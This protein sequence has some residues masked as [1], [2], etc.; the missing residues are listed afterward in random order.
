MEDKKYPIELEVISPLAVGNGNDKEWIK[1]LDFVQKDDKVY[2]LD[3]HKAVEQGVDVGRLTN[4]FLKYD[5]KGILQL[6]G[7]NVD[8][9]AK[10]VFVSPM[11]TE[12]KIKAFIRTQLFDKPIVAG[13]S[14]KG[15]IRSALF[16][17]LRTT[18]KSNEEVFG[19]MNEGTDFMRFI[20][21]GDVEM[22]STILVNSKIYN[23][24]G[25][26][27]QWQG[28]WKHAR[29]NKEGDSFTTGDYSPQGFNTLYECVAPGQK[30]IGN[31]SLAGNVYDLLEHYGHNA[32]SYA[33]R[34]HKL[35]HSPIS[36]LF[37]VVNNAT[38][39]YLTKEKHFFEQY[40]AQ[41]TDEIVSHIEYLINMIPTDGSSCLLKMSAGVGFHSI[42][43]DW[44]FDDYDITDL[45]KEGKNK[46]KKKYK[47]RK[48]ADYGSKLQ[49]MGF[50]KLRSLHKDEAD[51][52]ATELQE[53]HDAIM[54]SILAPIIERETA[55]LK[56]AEME[57]LRTEAQ[58]AEKQRIAK[59]QQILNEAKDLYE[60]GLWDEA[61]EKATEAAN[62]GPDFKDHQPFI[63]LCERDRNI[64]LFKKE[65][66]EIT[67]NVFKQPLSEVLKGK[68]SVGNIIGTTAKWIKMG[69]T[70]TEQEYQVL[71]SCL[72]EMPIKEIKKK[73][74]DIEKT[75]NIELTDRIWNELNIT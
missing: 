48:I 32:I 50:V 24:R 65:Q 25:H 59:Y 71:V 61:I 10:Y 35:I 75:I 17:F 39:V 51:V 38:K 2:I 13:S 7:N 21:V 34:K 60:K 6:L 31:I 46:D 52:K 16:H 12:N 1:G 45:W 27:K 36:E 72:K 58:E 5:E 55:R 68:S 69:N 33:D 73:R 62:L 9:V 49:L 40:P 53:Q 41:R 30:G 37:K 22:P 56:S 28:G 18:E 42:T 11:R 74:K 15:A 19:T 14:L 54:E 66:E 43:G 23:L 20:R 8:K 3:L 44:Q 64:A 67:N 4:L 29:T 57:R 47:S 26:G 70:F 63:E